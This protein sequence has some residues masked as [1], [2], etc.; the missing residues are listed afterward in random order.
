MAVPRKTEEAP[1]TPD[2]LSPSGIPLAVTR[3]PQIEMSEETAPE[4]VEA[5]VRESEKTPLKD[6][7]SIIS[8]LIKD[9]LHKRRLQQAAAEKEKKRLKK[10]AEIRMNTRV[11]R[12]QDD[13]SYR[14]SNWEIG[15]L[16]GDV[17]TIP[18]SEKM[19][20][21]RAKF[22]LRRRKRMC[23]FNA[24]KKRKA[25]KAQLREEYKARVRA[26]RE[27]RIAERRAFAAKVKAGAAA[28]GGDASGKVE[29]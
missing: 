15:R 14:E 18:G 16:V 29:A 22:R 8:A 26:N 21:R 13:Y 3:L 6:G 24:I 9:K 1:T 23:S 10:E 7:N 2:A 12:L 5:A 11:L 28:K 17:G 4:P 20:S 25:A 27:K 19:D